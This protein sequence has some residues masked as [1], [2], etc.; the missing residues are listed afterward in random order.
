MN[1]VNEASPASETSDV[2]RVVICLDVE[3]CDCG[4]VGFYVVPDGDGEPMQEQCRFCCTTPWSAFNVMAIQYAY[5][6]R[7]DKAE[8]IAEPV[9]F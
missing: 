7:N 5:A 9:P 6:H 1:K 8:A 3:H 2:E 4:D